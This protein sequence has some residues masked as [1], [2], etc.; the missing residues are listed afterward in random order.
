MDESPLGHTLVI[1]SNGCL[2]S[3]LVDMLQQGYGSA[4]SITG[5]DTAGNRHKDIAF[6]RGDIR[7]YEAVKAAVAGKDVVIN[8]VAVVNFNPRN[9]AWMEAI[10]VGGTD[11]VIKACRECN[12]PRLVHTSS[13][14]VV[15]NGKPIANGDETLPVP[16]NPPNHYSLTKQIAEQHVLKDNGDFARCALRVTGLYGPHDHVRLPMLVKA[17]QNN[18]YRNMGNRSDT[19]YSHVYSYNCAYAHILAAARLARGNRVDGSVYFVVD[20]STMNFFDFTSTILAA[21]GVQHDIRSMPV[22][23]AKCIASLSQWW[24]T[25]PWVPSSASPL[26]T[27]DAVNAIT[28]DL[29]FSGKL[30]EQDLGYKPVI[31]FEQG[32]SDTA[33][34]LRTHLAL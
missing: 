23:V 5:F 34:W 9:N 1:G 6:H 21:V 3:A 26:L 24:I 11:N 28:Q 14:D 25:L 30:A 20:D 18:I 29:W 15:Y 12:V 7:D 2:G 10:N 19:Q 4:A 13:M 16:K 17:V 32:I 31:P 27:R 8:T 22:V 33:K